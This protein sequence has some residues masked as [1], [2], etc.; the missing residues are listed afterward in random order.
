[1]EVLAKVAQERPPLVSEGCRQARRGVEGVGDL[2]EMSG[3]QAPAAG[4]PLDPRADVVGRADAD[5]R[6]LDEQG[7]RLVGLLEAPSDD[8]PVVGGLDRLGQPPPRRE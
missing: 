5:A 1:M 2:E 4:R 6:T 7:A 8:D 3:V